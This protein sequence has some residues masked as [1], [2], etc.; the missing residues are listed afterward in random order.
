[1]KTADLINEALSN[2]DPAGGASLYT[3]EDKLVAPG[4]ASM[5]TGQAREGEQEHAQ[6]RG[7]A[8]QY[9]Q[10]QREADDNISESGEYAAN[11]KILGTKK[12]CAG[13]PFKAKLDSRSGHDWYLV[14]DQKGNTI[15]DQQT[16]KSAD[17]IADMCNNGKDIN[18]SRTESNPN[19]AAGKEN[20][21]DN[22]DFVKLTDEVVAEMTNTLEDVDL[23][24]VSE[25]FTSQREH[26]SFDVVNV[27]R[28]R[29]ANKIDESFKIL[30]KDEFSKWYNNPPA[31][32]ERKFWNA[33]VGSVE[34]CLSSNCLMPESGDMADCYETASY[35]IKRRVSGCISGNSISESMTKINE[36]KGA[37]TPGEF[38]KWHDQKP[39]SL[40]SDAKKF[41]DACDKVYEI[42]Q[43]NK[44]EDWLEV[45]AAYKKLSSSDQAKV[46]DIIRGA[47]DSYKI[48]GE[49]VVGPVTYVDTSPEK[50]REQGDANSASKPTLAK[51]LRI[52]AQMVGA[53]L[54]LPNLVVTVKTEDQ[55]QKL[56][57][58]INAHRG[59][60][61][62]F[63]KSEPVT[64]AVISPNQTRE[65]NFYPDGT[66]T[67]VS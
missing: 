29:R 26:T 65:F 47:G 39:A 66:I 36:A 10:S 9:F 42:F 12:E 61:S 6:V 31:G 40:G 24:N 38:I 5:Y 58:A 7:S 35:D 14:V 37:L 1:M 44:L 53:S 15:V 25:G 19:P 13:A 3:G 63:G 28:G 30:S 23:Q 55:I 48:I 27:L 17:A 18:E 22:V 34:E 64:V 41:M 56:L 59:F 46:S 2:I 8:D 49:S 21:E 20:G 45:D 50:L 62:G 33:C 51:V 43:D 4:G 16:K 60:V 32:P 52:A 67:K 54:D 11:Y 57:Y